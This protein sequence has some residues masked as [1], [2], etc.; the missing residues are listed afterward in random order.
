M[1]IRKNLQINNL[2]YGKIYVVNIIDM[3]KQR[4]GKM[5]YTQ[6]KLENVSKV[7]DRRTIICPFHFT[8]QKGSS[9]AIVGHNGCGKST[10]LKIMAGLIQPTTGKISYPNGK[11]LFHYLP[12]KFYP[13][14]LKANTYLERMGEID[15]IPKKELEKKICTLAEDFYVS[16]FLNVPMKSLSKGT[17]QKIG[18]IQALLY[19]PEI[20]LLDEPLSGQDEDS[21]KV[22]IH[23]INKLREKG[24]TIIMSCHEK[25]LTDAL[26]EKKYTIQNGNFQEY[27]VFPE[28][29]EESQKQF[30]LLL[31]KKDVDTIPVGMER[32]GDGFRIYVSESEADSKIMNL[33]HAGWSLKGMYYERDVEHR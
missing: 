26:T 2:K 14:P 23:K 28:Y 7:Y 4:D 20:L 11:P 8:I 31:E 22:F 32:Y 19:E 18:V 17:L 27:K 16:E 30:C 9:I 5:D 13:T 25:E 3:S 1:Q 10:L 6:I 24:T 33:L 15:G 21:K 12:E 29:L